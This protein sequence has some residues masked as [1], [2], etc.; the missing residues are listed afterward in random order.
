ML[1]RKGAAIDLS[2]T[3]DRFSEWTPLGY[4][5]EKG[6]VKFC[7]HLLERGADI[8]KPCRK[9]LFPLEFAVRKGSFEVINVFASIVYRIDPVKCKT[10]LGECKSLDLKNKGLEYLPEW[11]GTLSDQTQ[12]NLKGNPLTTIPIGLRSAGTKAT[13]QYLR[14]ISNPGEKVTWKKAKIMVLGKEGV[15]KTHLFQRL[16]GNK[17]FKQNMSTDGVEINSVEIGGMDLNWFDFG[18]QEVFYPTHQFFLT[19]QCIYLLVFRLNDSDYLEKMKYWLFNVKTFSQEANSPAKMLV[20]GTHSD[21][22]KSEAVRKN[23]WRELTP[24][25]QAAGNV[26]GYLEVSCTTGKSF[27][28]LERGLS[29]AVDIARLGLQMIPKY[30]LRVLQWILQNR[31]RV[32]KL[33]WKEFVAQFRDLEAFQVEMACMFL[34]N[35]GY[36]FYSL[37]LGVMITDLQWLSKMFRKLITFQHKWVK[38]GVVLKKDLGQIWKNA[39]DERIMENMALLESFQIAFPKLEEGR[40]IIPCMLKDTRSG[41]PLQWSDDKRSKSERVFEMEL[42]PLGVMGRTMVRMQNQPA[43]RIREMWRNGM[44]MEDVNQGDIC[45]IVADYKRKVGAAIVVRCMGNT[46]S[47]LAQKIGDEVNAL[48]KS[49]FQQSMIP[50]YVQYVGCPHCLDKGEEKPRYLAFEEYVEMV[51]SDRKTFFC[52]E[53]EVEMTM[54]GTDMVFGNCQVF[55]RSDIAVEDKAFAAGAF[56]NI[57]KA[58]VEGKLEVVVKELKRENMTEGFEEFQLEVSF[59]NKLAHPN[60]VKLHGIMLNPLRMVIE[61]CDKGDLFAAIID[62]KLGPYQMDEAWIGKERVA[63]HDLAVKVILDIAKG[64]EFLHAQTPPIAHRDLRSPN[65]LMVSFDADT[66]VVAKVAD[67]GLSAVV[68]EPLQKLLPTWQWMAPEAQRGEGYTEKCDLYSFAIVAFEVLRG[69]TE[70]PPFGEFFKFMREA[71]LH[72]RLH[73][74]RLRPSIPGNV[75]EWMRLLVQEMWHEDPNKRPSFEECVKMLE[76]HGQVM[77]KKKQEKKKHD[78]WRPLLENEGVSCM[79]ISSGGELWVGCMD[80]SIKGFDFNTFKPIGDEKPHRE[81][82]NSVC[83]VG[84]SLWSCA[85]DIIIKSSEEQCSRKSS[86]SSSIVKTLRKLQPSRE[87][88]EDA[89]L[90]EEEIVGM[91]P[92]RDGVLCAYETGELKLKDENSTICKAKISGSLTCLTLIE[93]C[94]WAA[95]GKNILRATCT[96]DQTEL[97][98]F[99]MKE[100]AH[101]EAISAIGYAGEGLVWSCTRKGEIKIWNKSDMTIVAERKL[102]TTIFSVKS[103]FVDN[104]TEVWVGAKSEVLVFDGMGKFIRKMRTPIDG[105]VVCMLSGGIDSVFVSIK[106]DNEKGALYLWDNI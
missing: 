53:D 33:S 31:E 36:C 56:G 38:D 74:E 71:E 37:D 81:K 88:L 101:D 30:F 80:G 2:F 70:K 10:Q 63:M 65:V 58:A 43:I 55:G 49:V 82:V 29:M 60:L 86:L 46:G 87:K 44:V 67:F 94:G 59:M 51:T 12:L 98:I 25:M 62:G 45:E 57:Y 72:R 4:A 13:L 96:C 93:G 15:G 90:V 97:R 21:L 106:A 16:C 78:M 85:K 92:L 104:K 41:H 91:C 9:K 100:N 99:T 20:V 7:S 1:V 64:M 76:S 8:D 77:P 34:G 66:E 83:C 26:V 69:Q 50:P 68:S 18:G 6:N 89:I 11:M 105:D 40:W 42:L 24:V 32:P 47:T 28:S 39:S 14:D 79:D 103:V 3:D 95:S 48:L 75:P 84:K 102:E 27:D 5:I 17:K 61:Y 22:V 23:I 73:E 54:L 35:M 52:G 19:S